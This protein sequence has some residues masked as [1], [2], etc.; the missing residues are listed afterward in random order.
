MQDHVKKKNLGSK[1][2]IAGTITFEE[3]EGKLKVLDF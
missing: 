1:K 3:A 2:H